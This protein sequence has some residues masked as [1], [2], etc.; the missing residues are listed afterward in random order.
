[1]TAPTDRMTAA[2]EDYASWQG[3]LYE[4]LHRHP[5]LSM[6]EERTRAK[7]T[8]QLTEYG[9][10]VQAI[11]GGVVGVLANGE[12]P[13]VLMRADFDGLPVQEA[14]GLPYASVHT[15]VDAAGEV[16]RTMHACGHDFHIVAG[17]GAARLLAEHREDWSGTYIALFQPGE[18]IAAG[19]QAMVDDGLVDKLPRPEVCL[20]QH[21]MT[22]PVA[23][24]VAVAPGPMLSTAVSM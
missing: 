4:D 1:V 19:A 11:G 13:T 5:E 10:E 15:Q 12:G 20:G 23:G 14:S 16:V 7:I 17:L 8:E 2:L 18:E 6:L 3:P 21:V 22:T 9:Y 24:K